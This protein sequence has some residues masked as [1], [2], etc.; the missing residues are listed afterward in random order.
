VLQKQRTDSRH[1]SLKCNSES[2]INRTPSSCL[3]NVN[4]KKGLSNDVVTCFKTGTKR[5]QRIAL[6][7][8]LLFFLFRVL[9]LILMGLQR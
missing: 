5:F 1:R 7:I 4:R 3:T 6:R 2:F 9:V 8:L